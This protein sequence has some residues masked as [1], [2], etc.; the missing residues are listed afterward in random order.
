MAKGWQSIDQLGKDPDQHPVCE[1]YEDH[2]WSSKAANAH[3]TVC[4]LRLDPSPATRK[5]HV[6]QPSGKKKVKRSSWN[7]RPELIKRLIERDGGWFCWYCTI[8]L[9][10]KTTTIDHEV[11]LVSGRK[12]HKEANLRL[13]CTY[14]NRHK[15]RAP[16]ELYKIS[17]ALLDRQYQVALIKTRALK[18][19]RKNDG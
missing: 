1:T 15:G 17:V 12:Y 7:N 5:A 16:A 18:N 14:C 3:C 9:D 8:P 4:G 2:I 19:E 11:P 6:V 10:D 13:C